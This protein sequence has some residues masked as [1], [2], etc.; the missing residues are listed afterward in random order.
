[1]VS[2]PCLAWPCFRIG[3]SVYCLSVSYWVPGPTE[4][5]AII[6]VKVFGVEPDL[7]SLFYH[8]RLG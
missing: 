5:E 7:N 4:S 3:V 2:S 8:A 1:V 6:P